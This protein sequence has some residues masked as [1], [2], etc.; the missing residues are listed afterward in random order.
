MWVKGHSAVVGNEL[1]DYKAKEEMAVGRAIGYRGVCAPAGIRHKFRISWRT[2]WVA[3]WD[4]QALEGL[5]YICTDRRPFRDDR[6]GCA[7]A[8]RSRTQTS[9]ERVGKNSK[10]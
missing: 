4:R 10:T 1:A 8:E 7:S 2:K 5:S 6:E 3:E 9:S